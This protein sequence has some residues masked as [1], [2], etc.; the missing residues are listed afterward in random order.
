MDV[1]VNHLPSPTELPSLK[2]M[3]CLEAQNKQIYMWTHSE[4]SNF[5]CF[6]NWL[7]YF[8]ILIIRSLRSLIKWI[9]IQRPQFSFYLS[10]SHLNHKFSFCETELILSTSDVIY[11]IK[12]LKIYIS[13]LND[14]HRCQINWDSVYKI[15]LIINSKASFKG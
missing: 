3:N 14:L 1:D 10:K 11:I 2:N 9:S 6:S 7:C 12:W 15:T 8:E 13:D 4:N 5:S